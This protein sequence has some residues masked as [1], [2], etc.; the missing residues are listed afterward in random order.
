MGNRP[1]DLIQNSEKEEEIRKQFFFQFTGKLS[2][3][4]EKT[5]NNVLNVN[6]SDTNK[7]KA[8]ISDLKYVKG[9][10]KVFPSTGL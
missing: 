2:W 4:H 5:K 3:V 6:L 1:E 8:A 9:K 10:G 7:Y